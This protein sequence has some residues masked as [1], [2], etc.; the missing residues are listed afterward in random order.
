MPVTSVVDQVGALR[1]VG[2][3]PWVH[4]PV[5]DP[6]VDPELVAIFLKM[7]RQAHGVLPFADNDELFGQ[8]GRPFVISCDGLEAYR[9]VLARSPA[10]VITSRGIFPEAHNFL[11]HIYIV[12]TVP[13]SVNLA[14][15]LIHDDVVVGP[16]LSAT[17]HLATDVKTFFACLLDASLRAAL[18]CVQPMLALGWGIAFGNANVNRILADR[19]WADWVPS[20]GTAELLLFW[21]L[22]DAES[23]EEEEE[24]LEDSDMDSSTSVGSDSGFAVYLPSPSDFADSGRE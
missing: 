9:A 7:F 10:F 17:I 11:Q 18:H 21:E 2:L 16:E 4:D 5:V 8:P 20:M 22:Q 3:E 6:V 19:T 1:S 14:W 15:H 12:R 13:A 23:A 24:E